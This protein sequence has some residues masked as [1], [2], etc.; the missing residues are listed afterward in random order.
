MG[1][2]FSSRNLYFSKRGFKYPGWG[3]GFVGVAVFG[4]SNQW[5]N[6]ETRKSKE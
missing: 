1:E 5:G 3:I 2:F 6:R 4:S